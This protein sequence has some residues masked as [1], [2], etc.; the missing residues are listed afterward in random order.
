VKNG[1]ANSPRKV[2]KRTPPRLTQG[3]MARSAIFSNGTGT[4]TC[5][6]RRSSD[7]NAAA[8][9]NHGGKGPCGR[10]GDDKGVGARGVQIPDGGVIGQESGKYTGCVEPMRG[11]MDAWL[12]PLQFLRGSPPARPDEP[13]KPR[14]TGAPHSRNPTLTMRIKQHPMRNPNHNEVGEPVTK[15][16]SPRV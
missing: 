15:S 6:I 9:G 14:T 2:G 1:A 16:R 10:A 13:N 11:W 4:A 8:R 3:G 7:V 12:A 5:G